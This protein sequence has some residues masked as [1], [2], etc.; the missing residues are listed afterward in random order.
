MGQRRDVSVYRLIASGCIEENI[1][2]R[3][4]YKMHLS[5]EMIENKAAMRIFNLSKDN[6]QGEIFGRENL[7]SINEDENIVRTCEIYKVK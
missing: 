2:L 1:Y 7:F 6:K 4:I 5:K 3:Q